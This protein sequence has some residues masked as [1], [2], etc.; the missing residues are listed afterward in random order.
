MMRVG[1]IS[2]DTVLAQNLDTDTLRLRDALNAA[3]VASDVLPWSQP[4]PWDRYD[5]LVLRSPWDYQDRINEFHEWLSSIESTTRVLNA[6]ELIR[7]NLDKTYLSDLENLGIAVCPTTYCR[8]LAA[9]EDELRQY[10]ALDQACVVKPHIS[11]SSEN[12]GLFAGA[13]PA[14]LDLCRTILLLGKTVLIQPAIDRVQDG[15]ERGLVFFNG[16]FSHAISKGAI[17]RPG[18]GY[19]D[20]RSENIRTVT[21]SDAE[22]QLGFATVEAVAHFALAQRWS[23]DAHYPLYARIDVV[24]PESGDPILLEAELFEPSVYLRYSNGGLQ[25]FVDAIIARL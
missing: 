3:G 24:T 21:A 11:A 8:S 22:R 25:R 6:P 19:L 9:C 15:G 16:K 20:N 4:A 5:L 17:L 13:E 10:D 1:L 23:E 14:A 18:G 12:T 7:W 2:T